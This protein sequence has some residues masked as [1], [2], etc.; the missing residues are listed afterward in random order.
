MPAD[1]HTPLPN[2]SRWLNADVPVH[3]DLRATARDVIPPWLLLALILIYLMPAGMAYGPWK[4][5]EPYTFA[6]VNHL[7][8]TGDWVVP[9]LAGEPFL[10]KPP[11]M[12]WAA[13]ASAKLLAPWLDA[14]YGA[15]V[16]ILIFLI[17]TLLATSMAARRWWG[18]GAGRLA[19]LALISTLG[20]VQH[21]RMLIADAPQLAGMAISLLGFAYLPKRSVTGGFLLGT[22]AGIA[23][24]GKGL[25]V[26]GILGVVALSLPVASPD[27]RTR[28]YRTGL[29]VAVIAALPWLVIW[30]TALYLRGEPLF[31]EWFWKNNIGRFLG[32]SVGEL[33]AKHYAGFMLENLPWFSFPL[34]PLAGYTIW[35]HFRQIRVLPGL[36]TCGLCFGVGL[37]TLTFSASAR[38]VYLLPLLPPLAVLAVPAV[39]QIPSKFATVADWSARVLFTLLMILA[40]YL[41]WRAFV[42]QA[43][44]NWGFLARHLPMSPTLSVEPANLLIAALLGGLWIGLMPWLARLP[45]RVLSGWTTGIV[46]GW[47]SSFT[48]LLPWID[49]ARSYQPT[50]EA[51][52]EALPKDVRCLAT[53][54][55][56]ESERGMIDYMLGITP[57][58]LE[59]RPQSACNLVLWQS[60]GAVPALYQST[61]W[62]LRWR[63]ARPGETRE[64]FWLFERRD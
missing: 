50:F 4:P 5:D 47:T 15:R 16:A 8:Q 10:E 44:P 24:L 41:W 59:V 32:F 21:G 40:W 34:L 56:G 62:E 36:L 6:L 57:E 58:R 29:L 61:Q 22:G 13:A 48:L 63:G 25:L 52:A 55:L 33:G 19:V 20:M 64:Q 54:E 37:A 14:E 2:L 35:R 46:I 49:L 3:D 1:P 43:P 11:L 27:W 45:G 53:V 51:L 9:T 17:A 60:R 42:M 38:E 18:I 26:P 30:P 39:M 23:F 31:L 12:V 7:L 28:T